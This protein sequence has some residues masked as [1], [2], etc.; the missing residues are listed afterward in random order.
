MSALRNPLL[1]VLFCALLWGSA[2]PVIKDV[3]AYWEGLGLERSLSMILLF[4]GVRFS[5]AGG[6]LLL[7][8]NG[9]RRE[10]EETPWKPLLGFALAQTFVQYVFFYQAVAVS[11][12]SLAALL[13][14]T[15][16]FW[17]MLLAPILQNSPWPA[18]VQWFG[19]LIGGVGVSLAV[20]APGSGAGSPLLGATLMLVATASGAVAIIIFQRVRPTMSPINATG[21]SL[22]IGGLGLLAIG[23]PEVGSLSQMFTVPVL[24]ST[25]WLAFVSATA[26]SIWNHLSTIYPIPLLASYRF[27]IPVCGVLEAQLFVA[28]E[29]AG[30]GLLLGGALVVTSMIMA[31]RYARPPA[32][33]GSR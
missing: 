3:Y 15:G 2:F 10:L 25:V 18:P 12:A 30:W 28:G 27:L 33:N 26:F 23:L 22:L 13:V 6:G 21:L 16:S 9:L 19:L 1:P 8:G 17:W 29:S 20:Y 31:Q 5:L 24:V 7:F 4:A 11:S 14:A 32:L